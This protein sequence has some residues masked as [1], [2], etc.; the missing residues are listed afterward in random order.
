MMRARRSG[1]G[2][3]KRFRVS[4]VWMELQEA[5]SFVGWGRRDQERPLPSFPAGILV[6]DQHIHLP[7]TA[8]AESQTSR[9]RKYRLNCGTKLLLLSFAFLPLCQRGRKTV[10]QTTL[11]ESH[12]REKRAA[13]GSAPDILVQR[14]NHIT[15]SCFSPHSCVSQ[16][17][18]NNNPT[19][20][21]YM[22][23]HYI[24]TLG[25][26]SSSYAARACRRPLYNCQA[27]DLPGCASAPTIIIHLVLWLIIM[28]TR[29]ARVRGNS[30]VNGQLALAFHNMQ[31]I[32][33]CPAMMGIRL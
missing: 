33:E 12:D 4:R 24:V 22:Y 29:R 25:A 26:S 9:R 11:L 17:H 19:T 8:A 6:P 7:Q 2:L 1:A 18:D 23:V 14:A 32:A 3:A 31:D 13:S 30:N 28:T 16:H 15:Q 21:S 20:S 27:S 5:I 10:D